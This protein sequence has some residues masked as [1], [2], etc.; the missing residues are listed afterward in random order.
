MPRPRKLQG[1]IYRRTGAPTLWLWYWDRDGKRHCRPSSSADEAAARAELLQL[2][3]RIS[4][5]EEAVPSNGE[6][7][8]AAWSRR[9]IELRRE[10]G[11]N[12][13]D[14][15][16]AHLE[17][18][19]TPLLG[20][21]RLK[22]LSASQVLDFV[23]ALPMRVVATG[24]GERL[25]S[26][27]V[28]RIASTLRLCMREAAKRGLIKVSPVQLDA[29]DL[30][31]R[32]S[33]NVGEGF[34]EAEVLQLITDTRIPEDRRVLY[35]L[36]FLTGM[37]TGEAAA[38][39]WRDWDRSKEPLGA[40]KVETSWSTKRQVEKSTKTRVRR[41]IPV[42]PTLAATLEA[43]QAT[44]WE[45]FQG[46]PPGPDDL[47]VPAKDGTPRGNSASWAAFQEDLVAVGLAPQRHY[48]TRSTFL[49]LGEEAG[50]DLA[51]LRLLTHP[52]P[53]VAADLYRRIRVLWPKLCGA[54]QAI[55]VELL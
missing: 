53:R 23:R 15:E 11:K 22:D 7:T 24:R 37:R 33:P 44:G 14:N 46:H 42:H 12:E 30:P 36:E 28:H 21:V 47:M 41:V 17:H 26:T 20:R 4:R 5:G 2:L 9:W 13:A 38:R 10:A 25:S 43:W 32:G 8:V 27:T 34:S 40:L 54:V 29:S 50:A 31:E 1:N 35:V 45:R 52:S 51:S 39:R 18:H 16:A 19:I 49:S 6:L 48:E 55:R 3:G